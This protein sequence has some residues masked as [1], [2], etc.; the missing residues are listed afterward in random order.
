[1]HAPVTAPETAITA[2]LLIRSL[3]RPAKGR[4]KSADRDIS[5]DMA[6]AVVMDAP[7]LIAYFET[8]GVIIW[9]EIWLTMLSKRMAIYPLFHSF[10]GS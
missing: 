4:A 5:P 3:S 1:M 6:A 7:M 2:F 8:M 9:D 10:S